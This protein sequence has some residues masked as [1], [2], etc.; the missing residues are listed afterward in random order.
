[1]TRRLAAAALVAVSL[2]LL[3]PAAGGTRDVRGGGTFR[4]G[5]GGATFDSLDPVISSFPAPHILARA[6]C[7]GLV[8]HPDKPLPAGLRVVPELAVD[9]PKVTNGRKTYAF[10]IRRGARFSTGAPVTARSF[11][12]TINRLLHP[13]MKSRSAPGFAEIVGAREMIAGRAEHARGIVA[14]RDTLTI[15][16]TRPVSDFLVRL[17]GLCVVPESV[18]IDP[19]G[20]K[21]PV[22]SAG[23]YYAAQYD[24]GRRVVLERNR[25]YRG[26]RP[27]HVDRFVVDLTADAATI[28]ERVDRGELDYGW[29]PNQDYVGRAQEF[30]RKYGVNEGRFHVVPA[31]NLRM[32][33]LNT[34]R[35]LFRNNLKL[36]Q[37][38][39]FAV[40]RQAV[41]RE[42]GGTLA[43][44]LT[45]QYLPPRLPGFENER[46]YP[47]KT[48]DLA[49]A[50]ALAR[51]ATRSGKAILYIPAVPVAVAQGEVLKRSLARIGLEVEIEQFPF[52]VLV[53]KLAT[54]GEPFDIG[55]IGWLGVSPDGSFLNDLFHGGS[56]GKSGSSNYSYFD[57]PYFN[58]VLERTSRLPIGPE[59]NR[60][61]GAL[62]VAISRDAAPAIPYSYDNT[63]TL[64]SRR[65][66]C[67]IVNPELDLAAVCLK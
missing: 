33:V 6:T 5:V 41:Q 7:A 63:L 8:T 45:D 19:E 10:T 14:R 34:E 24:P 13:A 57:S 36:R 44:Y 28:L 64:V 54:R 42:R 62:D 52:P 67:V 15:N 26:G 53:E 17:V 60:A 50:R 20:V 66:G 61:Y 38:V 51:G 32:F 29:I 48:P 49:R 55:W 65:T 43:G 2:A 30:R 37:A 23:P 46:I 12:H 3:L 35:P 31:N 9:Y 18:P 1:M 25:F 47:L 4:V 56:I 39:N 58:R 11:A 22:P 16:L 40:D 59:R 21:A 27:H